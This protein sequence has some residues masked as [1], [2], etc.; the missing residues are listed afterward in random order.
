MWAKMFDNAISYALEVANDNMDGTWVKVPNFP[1]W[2]ILFGWEKGYM[3]VEMV[4][5][6]GQWIG[7]VLFNENVGKQREARI[8]NALMDFLDEHPGMN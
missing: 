1:L 7:A 4:W 3:E 2:R 5:S 6:D 8:M